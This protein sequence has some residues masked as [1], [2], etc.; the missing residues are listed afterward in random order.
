MYKVWP[1]TVDALNTWNTTSIEDHAHKR[2]V[3]NYAFSDTALRGAEPFIHSNVDR[4]LNLLAQHKRTD[5]KWTVSINMADQ[6]TYLVLDILG[7][8]SFGKCF[9]MKEPGSDLRYV[10]DLMVG[11]IAI[12]NP[13]SDG[14]ILD[15][16]PLS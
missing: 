4:W 13:V 2:R 7:D 9:D 12:M 8:L 3:L 6:I 5:D 15:H 1:R 11:F 10:V 16:G 14:R